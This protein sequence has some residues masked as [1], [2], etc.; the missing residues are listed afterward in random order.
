[1]RSP[2]LFPL[3]FALL[4]SAPF[5]HA[6][7]G[8]PPVLPETA[9]GKL[10]GEWLR[11]FNDADAHK[12]TEFV[13]AHY[14][15]GVL[16]GRT[17]D[18]I[19][20]GQLHIRQGGGTIEL[21]A[22]ENSSPT[23]LVATFKSNGTIPQYLRVDWKLDPAD[24]TNL[25]ASRMMPAEPPASSATAKPS[26]PEL[27]ED[28]ETKLDEMTRRDEFSGA[29][30]IA[31]DGKP[32]WQKAYGLADRE[33]QIPAK[34]ETRFRIGS[35]NK[36]FTG[37]A[38]AQLV[39]AGKL[40][41]TDTI[42]DVLPDYPN[43]EIAG[44]I[45]IEQ[46]LTHTSGLG[47]I[48]NPKF[49]AIKDD[50]HDLH[51]YLPLFAASPLQFEPGKT[52][53]YSNAGFVVLGLI[54]EKASGENYY[55]YV[56]HHIYEKAGMTSSGDIPK[57]ERNGEVAV[58]YQKEGGKL[59]PNWETLP[60]RGMSAGGGDSTVGDLLNF[61]NALKGNVLLS[62][63]MTETVT[64][65]KVQTMRGPEVKYA[66]GFEDG[67]AHGRRVVGHG[68]GAPGMNGDLNIIWDSGYTV[69]V[70]SNLDPPAA[71]TV[72]GYVSHQLP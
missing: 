56:Q 34:L 7:L 30:L 58:G 32:V 15:A 11:L 12:L 46:L 38:I 29:V 64:T 25:A 47:D 31:K 67:R 65:G 22:V 42:A 69:V 68:G 61:A 51:D 72:S 8:A 17:P 50:L 16:K 13:Q 49:D 40:K 48:F 70:L 1:M 36:M 2:R 26:L 28:L 63:K 10:M 33:K 24:P 18:Q 55:D 27:T 39:E 43:Q 45:T 41:F 37:V 66:Y 6:D 20:E 53:S 59:Q 44:K 71:D 23:D 9:P 19:A 57:T 21:A 5:A 52:W 35:M 54:V 62:P 60:W 14:G 4:L 3:L